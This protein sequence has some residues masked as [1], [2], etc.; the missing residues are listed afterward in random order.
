MVFTFGCTK[1]KSEL[2]ILEPIVKA[3]DTT[4]CVPIGDY[5]GSYSLV[6]YISLDYKINDLVFFNPKRYV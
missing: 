5:T 1:E 2:S 6:K 4:W 3:N